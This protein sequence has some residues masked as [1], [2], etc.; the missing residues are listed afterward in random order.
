MSEQREVPRNIV[1][2]ETARKPSFLRRV[3][4][5]GR[6][7]LS[8]NYDAD[9][10]PVDYE[11][12]VNRHE[13]R[14]NQAR[15]LAVIMESRL[16]VSNEGGEL[17]PA[18]LDIAAGTG[19]ISRVLSEK[20]YKVTATDLS[21]KALDSLHQ[22]SP[23]IH[24]QQADMNSGLPFRD[25][26]FDGATSVMGNRYIR[27]TDT[28]LQEVHR[29]LK[30]GGVFVWPIFLREAPLWIKRN[31]LRQHATAGKL[32][33]DG[34]NAGFSEGKIEMMSLDERREHRIPFHTTPLYVILKK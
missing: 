20:G 10:D 34:L 5:T 9:V 32:M 19:L 24:T 27:D 33:Q 13:N 29:V 31:G 7:A 22:R 4:T 14:T 25:D 17:A 16:P 6:V 8:G 12:H 1:Q 11:T 3:K 30:P 28:F 18:I 23:G 2:A 26:S 21:H 15:A